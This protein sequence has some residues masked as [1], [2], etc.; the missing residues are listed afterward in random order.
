MLL[1][2]INLLHKIYKVL[3]W[4][5]SQALTSAIKKWVEEM[6]ACFTTGFCTGIWGEKKLFIKQAGIGKSLKHLSN[7][8][9]PHFDFVISGRTKGNQV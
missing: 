9:D 5:W 6:T 7:A 3:S 1:L 4:E 8:V 2:I